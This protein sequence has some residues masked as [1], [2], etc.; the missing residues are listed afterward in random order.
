MCGRFTLLRPTKEVAEA[1]DLDGVPELAPRYNVAPTQAVLT[2]RAGAAGREWALMR[3]G[4]VPSWS[5]DA[6]GAAKLINARAETAAKK[7]A[8]RAAFKARR[9]V[10]PADGFYEWVQVG[11][12]K[13]PNHFTLRDGRVF[14]FAGLWEVWQKDG[15]HLETVSILTTEANEV[16]RF[17]HDRMPVIL[18]NGAERAWLERGPEELLRPYPAAEMAVRAVSDHVNSAGNEGPGCLQPAGP[19]Q[20]SLF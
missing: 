3:W 8:F 20:R 16:V 15:E 19:A 13:Q 6:R 4:L 7:P 11:R 10:V 14:G 2:V 17:A 1:F 9:C 12:K 18:P 5:A